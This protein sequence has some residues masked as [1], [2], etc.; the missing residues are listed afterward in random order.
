MKSLSISLFILLFTTSL[1]AQNQHKFVSLKEKKT[2]KRLELIAVNKDSI[3]YD[4]FL[5]V[6]TDDYRRTSLRPILKTLPP[7]SETKLLTMVLLD[8]KAGIYNSTFI[9][10]EVSYD[11][12]LRK[13]KQDI[14]FKIDESLKN[15]TITMFTK[16]HCV[17]CNDLKTIL[18]NNGLKYQE[19]NISNDTL[20][21]IRLANELKTN[22]IKETSHLPVFKINDSLYTKIESKSDLLEAVREKL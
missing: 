5:R 8:G 2:G 21:L 3:S 1:I 18:N 6:T 14:N 7:N 20:N 9:V 19:Y 12:S 13:D 22:K 15:K 4:V 10:N 11:F 16:D 17:L